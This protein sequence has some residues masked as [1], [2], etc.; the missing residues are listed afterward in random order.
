MVALGKWFCIH[1]GFSSK[2]WDDSTGSRERFRRQSFQGRKIATNTPSQPP[3]AHWIILQLPATRGFG[4]PFHNKCRFISFYIRVL[5]LKFLWSHSQTRVWRHDNMTTWHHDHD[6]D[7]HH[8]HHQNTKC[9]HPA[10]FLANVIWDS[11]V[12]QRISTS[13]L[14]SINYI[15]YWLVV[16]TPLKNMKVNGKDYPI[17]YGK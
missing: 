8:H 12:H 1:G 2:R 10:S 4:S 7:N 16:S 5:G 15:I 17:Y 9:H 13:W 11:M 14:K 3:K 6:H